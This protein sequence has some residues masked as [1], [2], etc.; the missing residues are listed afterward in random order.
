MSS[1]DSPDWAANRRV[2]FCVGDHPDAACEAW[3]WALKYFLEPDD[4]ITVL[5]V[6]DPKS[7]SSDENPEEIPHSDSN[8]DA[9]PNW[10]PPLIRDGLRRREAVLPGSHKTVLLPEADT[11]QLQP[12][13][14]PRSRRRA[15][16]PAEQILR[17]ASRHR[18]TVMI[19]AARPRHGTLER[20]ILGSTSDDVTTNA[21]VPCLVVMNRDSD[22][23]TSGVSSNVSTPTSESSSPFE[24]SEGTYTYARAAR[25]RSPSPST[26]HGRRIMIAVDA[27]AECARCVS[28]CAQ[29]LVR[30]VDEVVLIHALCPTARA[31]TRHTDVPTSTSDRRRWVRARRRCERTRSERGASWKICLQGPRPSFPTSVR[32]RPK[33]PEE[34]RR[35]G[36]KLWSRSPTPG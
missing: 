8:A 18:A 26:D 23:I 19:L 13:G 24:V 29:N 4:D 20:A 35:T 22:D 17:Y 10:L 1:P 25:E 15:S 14:S 2:L 7:S 5:R 9:E 32:A 30:P 34:H 36:S 6:W 33:T 21:E 3:S 12:V 11:P 28:W 16:T 27:S 31:M